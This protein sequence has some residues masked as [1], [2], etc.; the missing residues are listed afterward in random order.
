VTRNT[1]EGIPEDIQRA[2]ELCGQELE[3]VF[4]D[5]RREQ[6]A[7]T[8]PS[9]LYHYTDGLGLLGVLQSG[10]IRLTDIFGLFFWFVSKNCGRALA[11][12]VFQAHDIR[13]VL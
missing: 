5:L 7:F 9:L 11:Q 13:R 10:T 2:V 3:K 1:I 12:A 4:E 6:E 8:V